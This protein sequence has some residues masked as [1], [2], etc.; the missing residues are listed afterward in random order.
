MTQAPK[1]VR[2]TLRASESAQNETTESE[3]DVVLEV[4][5][6]DETALPANGGQITGT[7][8]SGD[9]DPNH[10]YDRLDGGMRWPVKKTSAKGD[11]VTVT[12]GQAERPLSA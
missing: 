1:S 9:F 11:A 2:V 12:V 3:G 8:V 10:D 5:A 6:D 7:V 4:S